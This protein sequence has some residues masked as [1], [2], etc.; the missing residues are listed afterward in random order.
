M[1]DVPVCKIDGCCNHVHVKQAGLCRRH[2]L[3]DR[4]YGSPLAG[5]PSIS[6]AGA[7]IAWMVRNLNYS[8]DECLIWPF[9][10]TGSGYGAMKEGGRQRLAHLWVCQRVHG[11]Q[12]SSDMEA[13]HSCGNGHLGCVNPRHLRWA[14]KVENAEDR[15]RH[16]RTSRGE[17]HTNAVL[18][19]RQVLEIY[20][21]KVTGPSASVVAQRY[22][23]AKP[24]VCCIWNGRTWSWLTGERGGKNL[25]RARRRKMSVGRHRHG[26]EYDDARR[27]DSG[28]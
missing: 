3:R 19:E 1:A 12:P 27:N 18:K 22:G 4:R 23:V 24:T 7:P 11:D 16:G 25:S 9:G 5:G 13:A 10:R 26:A 6:P 20:A 21:A 17:R 28:K 14:T 2:Y 8:G 15:T